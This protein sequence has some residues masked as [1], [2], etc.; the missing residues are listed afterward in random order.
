MLAKSYSDSDELDNFVPSCKAPYVGEIILE[1][2][3]HNVSFAEICKKIASLALPMAGSQLLNVASSFLC[4]AMLAQLGHEVLAASALIFTTQLTIMVTG[5]AI[6]FSLGILISHAYGAQDFQTIGNLVQQGWVLGTIISIPIMLLFWNMGSLMVLFGQS[7][8]V[9]LIVQTYFHA[10]V[11]AVIPGFLASCNMQFGYAIHKKTLMVI[12]SALSVSVLLISSYLFIFGKWNIPALGVAGLGYA[13]ALQYS[14]FFIFTTC[15]FFFKKD[16]AKFNLF[17][18]RIHKNWG[19][20]KHLFTTGWP[21]CMQMGGELLSLFVGGIMVGWIGTVALGAFQ[22]VNQ[23]YFLAIIPIFSLSQASGIV[24]GHAQ[25]AKQ[26]HEIKKISHASMGITLLISLTV[27]AVFLIYPTQLASFYIHVDNSD[28]KS[29][30]QLIIILFSIIAFSQILDAI[31]NIIIGILRGLLD[32]KIPMYMN[33]ISIWVLGMPLSYVLAFT[34]HFG[35]VGFVM[36]GLV[37][38][39]AA[40]VMMIF[41]WHA[42]SIFNQEL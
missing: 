7:K 12:C 27:A 30:L 41:R 20:L 13:T 28:N 4:M 34:L 32:T 14:L 23:Y 35:A 36:G 31:R 15:H 9:A 40:V 25:G 3:L 11:W 6:L 26:F 19:Q 37:G 21:I 16:F 33:L 1:N 17:H 29:T 18:F 42:F 2:S 10:L 22:V 8:E 24:V 38:M 39:L 5:M